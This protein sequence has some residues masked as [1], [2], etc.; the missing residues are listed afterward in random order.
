[1]GCGDRSKLRLPLSELRRTEAGLVAFCLGLE[2]G[3]VA[4]L[5]ML[6]GAPRTFNLLH[7]IILAK[8]DLGAHYVVFDRRLNN[9]MASEVELF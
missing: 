3:V 5:T 6:S 1:M 9:N 2:G 7:L 4:Y 8:C